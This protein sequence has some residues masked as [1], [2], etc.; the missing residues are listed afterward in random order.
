VGGQFFQHKNFTFITV[1][2]SGHSISSDYYAATK[3]FLKDITKSQGQLACH[4]GDTK[5]SVAS[6]MCASM[7]SCGK[8][9]GKGTCQSNGQCKCASS[10]YKG[11]D[12]SLD[13][14]PA[15]LIT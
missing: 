2:K 4:D 13:A 8:D 7:S 14:I 12:C 5:C 15:H 10:K 1:P 9:Q 3:A 6:N 11:S